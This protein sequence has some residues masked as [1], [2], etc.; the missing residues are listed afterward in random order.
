LKE[1]IASIRKHI[2]DLSSK[3][4]QNLYEINS[5]DFVLLFVP[6]EPAFSIAVENDAELFN[7]AFERN[8]V[9]VSTSTLLATLRTIASIWRL[10]NQNK[11]S[12]EIARQAGDLYDKFSSLLDD[13]ITVGGK[14]KD[15]DKAYEAAMNKLVN[16]RGNLISR[17][18]NLKKLGVKT[19]KQINQKLIDRVQ[20]LDVID[21]DDQVN[22]LEE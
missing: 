9:V 19:S 14:I 12:V 21:E 13:L 6:I 8:I 2:K 10:E 3:N 17:V 15:T 22:K 4:Y 1:H 5:L 11:N 20:D 18:E 7:E 16:G